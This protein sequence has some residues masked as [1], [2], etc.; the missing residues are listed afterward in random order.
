[1]V[2]RPLFHVLLLS[3]LVAFSG[4]R[5][6]EC[7]RDT[8]S[9][10]PCQLHMEEP[11][12]R[13]RITMQGDQWQFSHDGSGVIQMRSKDEPWQA[14]RARWSESGALC[15]GDLCTRGEIPLD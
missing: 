14:V 5:A 3:W 15:W 12:S 11:G 6:A 8:E 10:K 1:M 7:N 2:P 4:V 9:W 13:W